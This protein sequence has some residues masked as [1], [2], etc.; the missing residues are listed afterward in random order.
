MPQRWLWWRPLFVESP[1]RSA[2]SG[3]WM[4]MSL[5]RPEKISIISCNWVPMSV[6]LIS[7]R[8][9]YNLFNHLIASYISHRL[10]SVVLTV[11]LWIGL[12]QKYFL[13]GRKFFPPLAYATVKTP[14]CTFKISLMDI[15]V[16]DMSFKFLMVFISLERFSFVSLLDLI[17]VI[18]LYLCC[19]S[20]FYFYFISFV[21]LY[22][23][24][25]SFLTTTFW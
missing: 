20:A 4:S 6:S 15:S 11:F 5:S 24:A 16:S 23:L 21:Y 12:F 1:G 8:T 19:V 13:W 25:L 10:P 3:T 7:F 2:A 17:F 18:Y 14:N 9:A 22:P